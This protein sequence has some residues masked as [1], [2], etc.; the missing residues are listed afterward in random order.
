M[1]ALPNIKL[2]ETCWCGREA[3]SFAL[4]WV[5]T[6]TDRTYNYRCSTDPTATHAH[7]CVSTFAQSSSA[8]NGLIARELH[9]AMPS[10]H[11]TSSIHS[12]NIATVLFTTSCPMRSQI[13]RS[14]LSS[15]VIR[16]TSRTL[17]KFCVQENRCGTKRFLSLIGDAAMGQRHADWIASSQQSVS[18]G[19]ICSG[20]CNALKRNGR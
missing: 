20:K 15:R 4:N 9:A 19:C 2:R 16:S 8:N 7:C 1:V 13:W 5:S 14:P 12:N 10:K 6:E 18:D 17:K 3:I 11:F